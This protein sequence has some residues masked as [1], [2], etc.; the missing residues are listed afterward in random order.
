MTERI[1]WRRKGQPSSA[2]QPRCGRSCAARMRSWRL[3][4][5]GLAA[6]H[7]RRTTLVARC[8]EIHSHLWRDAVVR[9]RLFGRG[10]FGGLWIVVLCNLGV[11]TLSGTGPGGGAASVIAGLASGANSPSRG[12][13]DPRRRSGRR[14]WPRSTGSGRQ[15]SWGTRSSCRI[16]CCGA[17]SVAAMPRRSRWDCRGRAG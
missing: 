1:L 8:R 7:M 16:D 10:V 15:R 6:S 13:K 17:T 9:N 12:A 11:T 3:S 2:S 5:G 4:P 14:R